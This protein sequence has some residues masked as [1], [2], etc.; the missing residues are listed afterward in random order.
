MMPYHLFWHPQTIWFRCSTWQNKMKSIKRKERRNFLQKSAAAALLGSGAFAVNGKMNLIGSALAAKS[1]YA[2]LTDSK[3]LVCVY[4]SGGC[5]TYSMFLP[6]EAE[7]FGRYTASRG[8]LAVRPDNALFTGSGS[9]EVGFN[10]SLPALHAMYN[11]GE[12]AIVQNLGNLL[13]PVTRADYLNQRPWLP[14]NLFSHN[15]QHQMLLRASSKHSPTHL[16]SGWGGRMADL[17]EESND[18]KI[19]S[20]SFAMSASSPWLNGNNSS[21]LAV[22][23]NGLPVLEYLDPNVDI[24][25]N[26]MR[27]ATLNKIVGLQHENV[28]K[29][30]AGAAFS[31]AKD[32]SRALREILSNDSSDITNLSSTSGSLADSL[33][34]VARLIAG[35]DSLQM[36][37][38]LFF[39]RHDGWDTHKNQA[40]RM[41]S[42]MT[43][44]DQGLSGFQSQLKAQGLENSVTTFTL[45]EFG[46]SLAV[47]S[48]GTDH[49]WGAHSLIMGGSINGG[50]LHGVAP[51][52]QIGGDDDAGNKGRF[53]PSTSINQLGA[54]LAS[55]FGL[56]RS[57]IADV[58]PDLKYFES[59]GQLNLHH[60]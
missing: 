7:S 1:D 22:S 30:Q 3:A 37:R 53:I 35:R 47:N 41:A 26:K 25:G 34:M 31:S 56:S 44:L 51:S 23:P 16:G 36:K 18:N 49:G 55:W 4:L 11:T 46:R 21:A 48:G 27:E 45:S 8:S 13:A 40:D 10:A 38:Q 9:G 52:W 19:L 29:N 24:V 14:P 58:F 15:H 39:V 33:Q 20:Q 50:K 59:S 32:E 42:L 54:E 43:E 57:D 2:T 12:L 5:D 6:A 17:M 28:L 60:G